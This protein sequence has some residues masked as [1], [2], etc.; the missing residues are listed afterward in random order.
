MEELHYNVLYWVHG[1]FFNLHNFNLIIN[2]ENC[3]EQS[4]KSNHC[5]QSNNVFPLHVCVPRLPSPTVYRHFSKNKLFPFHKFWVFRNNRTLVL[6]QSINSLWYFTQVDDPTWWITINSIK[7]R[8]L[9][10]PT[11]NVNWILWL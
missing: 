5:T 6:T 3:D 2:V 4:K 11:Y 8:W 7:L 9:F 1:I 10:C